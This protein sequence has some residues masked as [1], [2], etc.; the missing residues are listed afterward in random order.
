[1]RK[2]ILTSWL[3]LMVVGASPAA[4]NPGVNAGAEMPDEKTTLV[5]SKALEEKP[6]STVR[7]S[8]LDQE[9]KPVEGTTVELQ[10]FAGGDVMDDGNYRVRRRVTDANGRYVFEDIRAI[11]GHIGRAFTCEDD[12]GGGV[13]FGLGFRFEIEPGKDYDI[14]LGG[15]GRPVIGRL[16]PASG[17][18]GDVDW[19][20]AW[21]GFQLRTAPI[22]MIELDSQ[23]RTA[24][25]NVEGGDFYKKSPVKINP[26][27]TFRIENVRAGRYMLRVKIPEEPKRDGFNLFRDVRIPL[28]PNG[29]TEKPFNLGTLAVS[30]GSHKAPRHIDNLFLG[31]LV[32][33]RDI[34][35]ELVAGNEEQPDVVA[36]KSIRFA[37]N[38]ESVTAALNVEWKSLVVDKWRAR[39]ALLGGN[40]SHLAWD[41]A[42]IETSKTIEKYPQL[43]EETLSFSFSPEPDLS[44]ISRFTITIQPVNEVLAGPVQVEGERPDKE[45]NLVWGEEVK[46]LRAAVEFVPEKQAYTGPVIIDLRLHIQNVSDHP[47]QFASSDPA[48]SRAVVEDDKGNKQRLLESVSSYWR[49]FQRCYLQPG[50]ELVLQSAP[51]GIA[52]DYNE[53]EG[54]CVPW[55][56]QNKPGVYFARFAF[57]LSRQGPQNTQGQPGFSDPFSTLPLSDEDWKGMLET[58]RHK[59]VVGVD[60]NSGNRPR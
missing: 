55:V 45:S 2:L 20:K 36:A 60:P 21:V 14:T 46:G 35:V 48:Y 58:G 29:T 51:V 59:L 40:G 30:H 10:L 32:F 27:G 25:T 5:G 26:D 17:N 15:K 12:S 8:V 22:G 23:R 56:L 31:S 47:I 13:P 39:L 33:D 41:D 19:S 16:V 4:G 3:V 52:T 1:M 38:G 37:K 54:L 6:R 53:A 34:A 49:I 57:H 42:F 9:G 18:D 11:S 7:G 50:E 43:V 28:M 24:M 44:R